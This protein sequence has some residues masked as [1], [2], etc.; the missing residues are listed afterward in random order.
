MMTTGVRE[1]AHNDINR[2]RRVIQWTDTREIRG[3]IKAVEQ[4]TGV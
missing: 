4:T 3:F 1:L 2:G